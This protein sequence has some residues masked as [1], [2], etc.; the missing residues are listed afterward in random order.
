MTPG[1]SPFD[2]LLSI[3][4]VAPVSVVSDVFTP[5]LSVIVEV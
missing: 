5:L 3:V 2:V 4:M 1:V